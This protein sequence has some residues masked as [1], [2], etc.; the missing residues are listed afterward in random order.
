MLVK[1]DHF[2]SAVS[3]MY[4]PL[5]LRFGHFLPVRDGAQLVR[6]SI[7]TEGEE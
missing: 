5:P 4:V 6:S 2:R 3:K 7:A 1:S